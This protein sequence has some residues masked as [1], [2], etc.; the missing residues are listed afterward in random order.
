MEILDFFGLLGVFKFIACLWICFGFFVVVFLGFL[1]KLL[2][3]LLKVTK[4]TTG[5]A[6]NVSAKGQSPPPE[7]KIVARSEPYLLVSIIFFLDFESNKKT[8]F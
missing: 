4:V 1:S 8:W 2:G 6:K 5:R 7:L 3:L